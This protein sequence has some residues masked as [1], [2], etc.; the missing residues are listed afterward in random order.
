MKSFFYRLLIFFATVVALASCSYRQNIMFQV[1]EGTQL[2]KQVAEAER[3]YVIQKNDYLKLE[4]YTNDGELIIDPDLKLLKDMPTQTTDI[5]PDP[6]FLV[7]ING[8]V[9]F[10]M[11]GEFPLA[12]LSIRQAEEIL[13]KE[14]A[15]F[16]QK[17]FVILRYTNK[18]VIVLGAPGGKIIPLTN[19][20]ITLAEVLALANAIDN[21]SIAS[22]MR[23]LRGEQ[24]FVV[25]F[26]T[27]EGYQKSNMIMQPGDIVYVEPVRRPFVE[28]G[29]DYAPILSL[30]ISISTLIV[31]LIGY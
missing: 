16:Y 31:V 6:D 27:L 8:K 17:P 30:A 19:E 25:D 20:N 29:R 9:K 21:N 1:P 11:I 3:N 7:D 23:I 22:N 10:P 12:G 2:Q 18:R 5:Q 26:S 28:A 15:K 13:Q 24:V 14:Y 4:V